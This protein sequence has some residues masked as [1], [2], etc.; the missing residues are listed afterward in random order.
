[1]RKISGK[2]LH[3]LGPGRT[4]QL[5]VL[6]SVTQLPTPINISVWW[7]FGS[8]LGFGL[9]TQVITGIFLAMHYS[10]N[11]ETAYSSV[12]HISRDV[13]YG[14]LLRSVHANMASMYFLCMFCHV[15]RGI[16]Y[17]SY[18]FRGVWMVGT[19]LL[20]LSMMTAFLGYV[21]PWGQMSFWGATV[22]TSMA[23]A[24]PYI[25]GEVVVW[26][27]GGFSVGDPTLNRFFIFHFLA[28]FLIMLFSGIHLFCLHS[29][30][31][32][33]PIGVDSE[34][35][36][37]HSYFTSKDMVGFLALALG[38]FVVVFWAPQIFSDPINYIPANPLTTPTH[39]QPEWYF[40]FAY[41]IL[42]SIPNKAGGVAAMLMSVLILLLL[43]L[44]HCGKMRV[45]S[46]YFPC[47]L[48]FWSMVSSFVLLT[49]IG[50]RPVENPF[51]YLGVGFTV[52][53]FSFFFL[54]A[55]MQKVW[56]TILYHK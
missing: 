32:N 30:G 36:C 45:F 18:L 40:L 15:G 21:L 35:V 29:T 47:Q 22:I 16:Y 23:S 41:T 53:Y 9:I 27:W 39:I 7:N 51:D 19:I 54:V 48:L 43:P 12:V 4:L 33:N 3:P 34:K 42:R 6:E 8:M 10:P 46:Y 11:M 44:V 1:M 52:W 37:F 24:V 25:G 13:N 31:S 55:P 2:R 26:L 5:S 14:W 49:W 56:D 50:S 28:P 17:G 38:L 20:L